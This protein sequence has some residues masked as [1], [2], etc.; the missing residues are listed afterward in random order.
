[1]SRY[2]DLINILTDKN[3][4]NKFE[5]IDEEKISPEIEENHNIPQDYIEFLRDIGYGDIGDGYYMIYSGLIKSDDIFDEETAE[6]LKDILFFGDDFN[7]YCTGFLTTKNWKLV[8][9]NGSI[10]E[11]EVSFESFIKRKLNSFIKR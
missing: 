6:E 3:L 4:I 2:D 7:G 5:K 1:M 9:V 11:L 10:N 8:E